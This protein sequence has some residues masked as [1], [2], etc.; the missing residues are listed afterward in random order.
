M[1]LFCRGGADLLKKEAHIEVPNFQTI[2]TKPQFVLMSHIAD[3]WAS[4]MTK[5]GK[6]AP[7]PRAIVGCVFY[8]NGKHT[9]ICCWS[10]ITSFTKFIVATQ[11]SNLA[12]NSKLVFFSA[13][14]QFS[15]SVNPS[16]DTS[17]T[18]NLSSNQ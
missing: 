18:L 12:Y 9:W 13:V 4:S 16:Y 10:G 8:P 2:L 15:I 14:D 1:C 17:I 3:S 6:M 11:D 5:E 7:I